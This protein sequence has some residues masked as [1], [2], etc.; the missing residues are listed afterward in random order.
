MLGEQQKQEFA[1]DGVTLLPGLLDAAQMKAARKLYDWSLANPGPLAVELFGAGSGFANDLV[2][3]QAPN[4]YESFLR[5]G[6]FAETC[7]AL[8]DA[9]PCWFMYEQVFKKDAP[10]GVARTPWHQDLPYLA[11]EG[12][13]L[14]VFWISFEALPAS[15]S[16]EFVRGSHTGTLYNGSMFDPEDETKPIYAGDALPRL[17]RIEADRAAYDI[18][19]FA[20][21]PGDVVVFHPAMLHGGAPTPK[22]KQRH[23]LSLRFFGE[24]SRFAE[25]PFGAGLMVPE[26]KGTLQPGDPF[27]HEKFLELH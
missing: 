7:G 14:A 9:L 11:I 2:N 5:A 25:R 1:R 12:D 17:P 24:D 16:L 8:W 10:E 3:P 20:V 15:E 26:L 6:P 23:T 22:D 13:H 19:S 27:R 21:E 18:V 4:Q